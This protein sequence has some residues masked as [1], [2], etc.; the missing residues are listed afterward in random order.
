M[1]CLMNGAFVLERRGRSLGG[2]GAVEWWEMR[3]GRWEMEAESLSQHNQRHTTA[4]WY[5]RS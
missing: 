3:R 4:P 5:I 1:G 2:D